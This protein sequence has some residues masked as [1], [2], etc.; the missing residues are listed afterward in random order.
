MITDR[1]A[2]KLTHSMDTSDPEYWA[3]DSVLTKEEAKFMLSFG[4]IRK[5]YR[6][7]ELAKKNNITVEH[8]KELIDHLCWIGV[9]EM[10][11]ENPEK[12]KQ[13]NVP[14]FVPGSAEF[15]MM[16]DRLTDEHPHLAS[17]FNLMTQVP[18][19]GMTENIPLGGAGV[20]M[21]VIP[22]EKAIETESRSV[23]VEHIS[24]WLNKYDK[25]AVGICTCRKQQTMRGEGSGEIGGEF[26]ISV[27]DMAEFMVDR[28]CSRYITY[29]EALEILDRSEK[30]GFVHQITNVD[31]SDK[32]VAICNCAPGVCNALRT[33]QLYNTPNLSRSAYRAHVDREKCV[34]CGKC[35]E[36]CPVGAAKL[37]QKLCRKDGSEVSYP[38]S[39]LPD[40]VKWGPEKWNPDYRDTAKINCY[41]S[42]TAPCKTNCPAH[43]AVQGYVK[44]ASEGRYMEALRLIKQDNPFPAVCGAICNRRCEDACTRGSVDQPIAID[45]IKKFIAARELEADQRFI[46][47]CEKDDGGMWGPKYKM[48]VIGAGPAGM[49]AAYYLRTRGYDVTVFEKDERPGGMLMNGVPNFR[50]EKDVLE[51]E[52]E[53]LRTMGVEFR[54]GVEVGKDVT[55]PELREQGYKAFYLSIG[56][57]GGRKAGVPGEDAEGVESGVAFLKRVASGMSADGAE[58]AVKLP[59]DVVVVGG[60]NVAVDV[61]RTAARCT[62]G[63]VTMLCLESAEEM[64]AARDEVEDAESEGIVVKNGWGPKEVLTENGRVTG[65]VFK[66]CTQ[67]KDAEGRFQP[68]YDENDTIAVP[69]STVLQAIGQSAEWGALLEG[70]K[71]ELGRGATVVHDPVT[72]QTGEPDIFVGGDI[73][74]GARF[75][76]DA[77]ADGKK[78]AES[79]HRFVHPGQSLTIGRDRREFIQLDKENIA[80]PDYDR[81]ARQAPGHKAGDPKGTFHDLRLPLTEEQIRA[82]A[83]RCLG[84]GATTVDLNRCIGCGLCTTRCEFDAI[85]LTRD[86]P[87]ASNMIACDN[88][89]G[90]VAKYAAKRQIK[91]LLNKK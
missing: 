20:G 67:V 38:L 58:A 88:K 53:V 74:H 36:V 52:I 27:G 24:H 85:H 18:L 44:M 86:L 68:Q 13:Y 90:P 73:G 11:R 9:V 21:H 47:V 91:I 70:T 5:P 79:M 16:N 49:T 42:G 77:I 72:F 7:E 30:H 40:A 4:K 71:V 45:E 87:E 8:A 10:N 35:V 57:Q 19:E 37:G 2:V 81:T 63:R 33:S 43:L 1:Y 60:G 65:I 15:M 29:E 50:L 78:G 84:C 3:L 89:I 80:L 83:N 75:A 82:E 6:V 55:I 56:L 41:D 32:I 51:A 69:C 17:F 31:G 76:I 34:A 26:C 66:R 23:S 48:A 54:C 59:G 62:S 39:E 12:E 28:E 64:P 46:P 25:Y 22:V 61:A 14:I